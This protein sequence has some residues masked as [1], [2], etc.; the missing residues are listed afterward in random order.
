MEEKNNLNVGIYFTLLYDYVTNIVIYAKCGRLFLIF[1]ISNTSLF[2][3]FH[4]QS[5]IETRFRLLL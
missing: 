4:F 2:I 5:E 3:S 1:I